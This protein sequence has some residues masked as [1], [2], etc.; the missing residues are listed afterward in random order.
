M[1]K[2]YSHEKTIQVHGPGRHDAI[3]ES[4]ALTVVLLLES[5]RFRRERLG[6]KDTPEYIEEM[7]ELI[8]CFGW[9]ARKQR[10]SHQLPGTQGQCKRLTIHTMTIVHEGDGESGPY[11]TEVPRC[12]YHGREEI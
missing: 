12:I 10:C 4:Q 7:E 3:S 2:S 9:H 1:P 8:K 11:T 6:L 5:E